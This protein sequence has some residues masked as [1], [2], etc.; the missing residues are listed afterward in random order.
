MQRP[1]ISRWT[2]MYEY[3]LNV[4]CLGQLTDELVV[5]CACH[6]WN[7][8]RWVL[9]YLNFIITRGFSQGISSLI[10]IDI[11][12]PAFVPLP[13]ITWTG[14]WGSKKK[15]QNSGLCTWRWNF[16]TTPGLK[17]LLNYVVK[18]NMLR[19]VKHLEFCGA[20][21]FKW[22]VPHI[23]SSLAGASLFS[24]S[25]CEEKKPLYRLPWSDYTVRKS[26]R[27]HQIWDIKIRAYLP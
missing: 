19:K 11:C 27:T 6:V 15:I 12:I 7:F 16:Y 13:R 9:I 20:C 22:V 26:F 1:L 18:G 23:L 17:S 5:K 21:F 3:M 24:Q 10:E 14:F 2:T 25:G 4:R 8:F